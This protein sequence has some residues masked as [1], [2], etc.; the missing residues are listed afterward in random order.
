[1]GQQIFWK[2]NV[3]A[4]ELQRRDAKNIG[5]YDLEFWLGSDFNRLKLTTEAEL[6]DGQQHAEY[7]AL[8]WQPIS[9]F[10]NR[11]IGLHYD[12]QSQRS[13]LAL[14]IEG[15]A[16]YWIETSAQLRLAKHGHSSL[17]IGLAHDLQFTR[18]LKL[19]NQLDSSLSG[20]ADL[21]QQRGAGLNDIKLFSRLSYQINPQLLPY[22]GIR[23]QRWFA[24]TVRLRK[25]S[26]EQQTALVAGL[27]FWF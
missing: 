5:H 23:Y 22:I 15:T 20:R 4:L 18:R 24:D 27:S 12:Q 10:W 3:D 19:S 26:S 7:T 6:D 17:K 1:M 21:A 2:F 9:A 25:Q 11:E 8:W 14:G 13:S 16:P